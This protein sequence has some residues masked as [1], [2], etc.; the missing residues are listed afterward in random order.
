MTRKRY[1]KL[2]MSTGYSRNQSNFL[3][4]ASQSVS[5]QKAW[6]SDLR[7]K[8]M[9]AFK[10][11]VNSLTPLISKCWNQLKPLLNSVDMPKGDI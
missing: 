9:Y 2:L 6:D 4:R 11:I 7:N 5:Y 8:L 3:A 10:N 1:V